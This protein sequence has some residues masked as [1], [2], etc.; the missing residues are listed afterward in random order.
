LLS[1]HLQHRIKRHRLWR[2]IYPQKGIDAKTQA[3]IVLPR[4]F[5]R[6]AHPQQARLKR[7]DGVFD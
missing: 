2:R 4:R 5:Q 3:A 1:I 7:V 6:Y